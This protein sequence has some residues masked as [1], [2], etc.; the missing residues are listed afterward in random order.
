MRRVLVV[1]LLALVAACGGSHVGSSAKSA[2]DEVERAHAGPAAKEGAALAPQTY[3]I[4]EEERRRARDAADAGDDLGAELH[5]A[6]ALAAY[7]HALVLARTARAQADEQAASRALAD[8]DADAQRLAAERAKVDREGDELDKKLKI[9]HET[10]AP[11]TSAPADPQREAARL[12]A[13]RALVMQARLLCGSARLLS[14]TL[15]GLEAAEKDVSALEKSVEGT[16]KPAPI[17]AAARARAACLG[18]LTQARRGAERTSVGQA[19]ALLSELSA[20]GQWSPVRDE[21]G[22][23]VT[24]RDAFKGTTVTPEAEGKLKELGRVLAAH[25]GYG[26][27][28]VVHDASAPSAAEAT[29][30]MQRADAAKAA[31]A[32]GAGSAFPADK[33]RTETA[34][35]RAPVIDPADAK[36]RARNARLE[37][38][39]VTPGN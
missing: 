31:L 23:V 2:L 25:P 1:P 37:I 12:V 21:R 36:H 10:L 19:D 30:D 32:A 13:A 7:Q 29:A 26:M 9:A 4:A 18:V 14:A 3:A 27:Q 15:P 38:V 34:G 6:H 39:F 11:A 20:A 17:D 28:V 16:P 35:A 5:A 33:I 8:A 24:L 22:V